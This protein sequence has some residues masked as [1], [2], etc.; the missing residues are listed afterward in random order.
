MR[1]AGSAL[2]VAVIF[3]A[4]LAAQA[5]YS[6]GDG[7]NTPAVQ[8]H[9][10]WNATGR[11][12]NGSAWGNWA[13]GGIAR[14]FSSADGPLAS[15]NLGSAVR[16]GGLIKEATAQHWTVIN[17]AGHPLNF[18]H[19]SSISVNLNT[20]ATQGGAIHGSQLVFTGTR[21]GTVRIGPTAGEPAANGI[22]GLT[23]ENITLKLSKNH[24]VAALGGAVVVNSGIL[25]HGAA[26]DIRRNNQYAAGSTL[27]V[28]GGFIHYWSTTQTLDSLTWN[29]G[30]FTIWAGANIN[31][32]GT[33]ALTLRNVTLRRTGGVPGDIFHV[34]LTRNG[35]QT[36][37][38][39]A[40]DNG[41][42]AISDGTALVL[43]G[44]EKTFYVENGNATTDMRVQV[45]S[46]SE[47][48]P[49]SLRKTGTGLL[50]LGGTAGHTGGTHVEAGTMLLAT[51][52]ARAPDGIITVADGASLGLRCHDGHF[53]AGDFAALHA[54]TLER[55]SMA[56]G[57]LAGFENNAANPGLLA[58]SLT[59]TRG[60]EKLGS[61][62]L[63]LTADNTYSGPTKIT[64]GV[65][66]IGDGGTTGSITGDVEFAPSID[67]FRTLRFNRNGT[68]VHDGRISG[69]GAVLKDGP[70]TVI[71]TGDCS[72]TGT[73]TVI[74][75]ELVISNNTFRAV[76]TRDSLAVEF[77]EFPANGDYM[78]LPGGIAG[79]SLSNVTIT[80]GGSTLAGGVF[81]DSPS[82]GITIKQPP[83]A[84][85]YSPAEIDF[86]AGLEIPPF[87]PAVTGFPSSYAVTPALPSGLMLDPQ[88]GVI[89]GTPLATSARTSHIITAT[90]NAGATSTEISIVIYPQGFVRTTLSYGNGTTTPAVQLN[91]DWNTAGRW[92]DG[93][94]WRDWTD[95]GIARFHTPA[96]GP[97]ATINLGSS[98]LLGGLVKAAEANHWTV[99]N[100]SG[101]AL[102]FTDRST[103]S[104]NLNTLA[105]QGGAIHG[106]DLS[107]TGTPGGFVRIG[108]VA[109]EAVA[110]NINGLT[111]DNIT[112]KLS[113]NHGV[114]AVGG[115]VT[116]NGGVLE[117]GAA[118]DTRRN[119]QYAADS[120][121]TLN[122]GTLSYWSTTQT[123]DSLTWNAGVFTI[124][125]NANLN[126][127]GTHALT[128][129]NVMLT[130]TGGSVGQTYQVNLTK[131]GAQTVRFDASNNG[132]ATLGE[133]TALVLGGG[134]K[135]IHIENG[136]AITDMQVLVNSITESAPSSI[137]KTGPGL[138][139]WNV[140]AA[141][142]HSGGMTV[143]NGTLLLVSPNSQPASGM[144]V[145]DGATLALRMH[146]GQFTQQ[147]FLNLHAGTH[148]GV[149]MAAA[150]IAGWESSAGT[151]G[152]IA[153]PL[154]GTRGL[155]K[156]GAGVLILTG[157]NTYSGGTVIH[158]G[159]LQ[160][161]NGGS[162]GS[163]TGNVFLQ[164]SVN[165]N[166][167]LSFNRSDTV[168]YN[169]DISG[170][171][172]LVKEGGGRLVLTGEC[173]H[174]GLTT[175]LAG[176]LDIS[177]ESFNAVLTPDSIT[178]DFREFPTS[179]EYRILAG[180]IGGNS[181]A[182]TTV[183]V[184]GTVL[185][186]AVFTNTSS[187][188]VSIVHP[189]HPMS[190]GA[191]FARINLDHPGLEAV[192]D[193]VLAGN[194]PAA[195]TALAGY[196]RTRA[197]VFH[198][199]DPQDPAAFVTDPAA[200]LAAAQELV[201]R[202]GD[203][204][205][206]LWDGNHFDWERASMPGKERME[207]LTILGQ[208]AAVETGDEA[209]QS[210]VHLIRSFI[211]Q[212]RA[213]AS[214]LGD[215]FWSTMD[216]GIRLRT[217]WPDAFCYLLNNPSSFTDHDIMF[218][219]KSVWEQT[220]YL[221]RNLNASTGPTAFVT[222]GLYA[223]GTVHP[224]FRDAE[225][226]RRVACES[227]HAD[228]ARGWLP[229]GVGIGKSPENGASFLNHLHVHRIA[230]LTGRLD[231]FN[232][233]DL[234]LHGLPARTEQMFDAYLH[235]MTPDR[236]TPALN[237]GGPVHVPGILA[238][239]LEYFPNRD[240]YRWIATN[241]AAGGAP[242]TTTTAMPYAGY[243]VM[244][245]GWA[246]DDNY[247]LFDAGGVGHNHAHQDKL[248]LVMWA[249]GRRILLDSPQATGPGVDPAF[250][251][252]FR[253]TFAH[254]TGLVDGRPQRRPWLSDPDPDG[255]PYQP[256]PDFRREIRSDG[257][258]W[259][260]GAYSGDYGLPG[261]RANDS[262]PNGDASLF[263][264][265]WGRPASH[266][267]E[268]M[269]LAPDVFVVQDWF[270]P[271][272]DMAH[273]C[274]VRWQVDSTAVLADGL[275]AVTNDP[276]V[277]NLAI[278]PLDTNGLSTSTSSGVLTADEIAG[279]KNDNG[280]P[281]PATTLHHRKSGSG[282]QR[283][284]T[285]LYPLR[286]GASPAGL[287]HESTLDGRI[288]IRTPDGRHFALDPSPT[289]TGS[290]AKLT[291]LQAWRQR[292]FGAAEAGAP[293]GDNDSYAGDTT[294][295]LIKYALGIEPTRSATPGELPRVGSVPGVNDKHLSLQFQRQRN[296]PDV[297]MR[298]QASDDLVDWSKAIWDSRND[299][300]S[301]GNGALEEIEV[302]DPVPMKQHA[303]GRNFLRLEVSRLRQDLPEFNVQITAPPTGDSAAVFE[304][305][306]RRI[307]EMAETNDISRAVVSVA[308]GNYRF[309][310]PLII[311]PAKLGR[312]AGQ[313]VIEATGDGA[314]FSGSTPIGNWRLADHPAL[315]AAAQGKVWMA[316]LPPGLDPKVLY[317]A[318]GMLPRSRSTGFAPAYSES[319][320]TNFTGPTGILPADASLAGVE[321]SVR[322]YHLWIHNILP[323]A[324][325][326][327]ATGAGTTALPATYRISLV[328]DWLGGIVPASAW[329]ENHPALISQAGHWA[330]DPATGKLYVWPRAGTGAPAGIQAPQLIELLRLQGDLDAEIPL[331]GVTLRGLTFSRADRESIGPDD[332]GL[333]HDWDFMDKTNAML[334]LRW[335]E[336]ITVE[337]CR[338]V[339]SGAAGMRA[340]LHAQNVRV[341]GNTFRGLGGGGVLFCGYGPGTKDLNKNNEIHG[342]LIEDCGRIIWHSPGIHLW[343]SGENRVTR[344][345]VRD[346]PYTGII[347]SGAGAHNFR[348]A[349]N[350][351][352]ELERTIR[353]G[354]VP[355]DVNYTTTSIQ[356]YIHTRNNLIAGN[357]ITGVMRTLGDGNAIYIRFSSQT[358][359]VIRGNHVHHI[360]GPR[361]AGA[362]RCD[363]EQYGVT[364]EGNYIHRVNFTGVSINGRNTI[365]N[366]FF[367]DILN[368]DNSTAGQSPIVRACIMAWNQPS[369]R[370]SEIRRNVFLQTTAGTPAFYYLTYATYLNPPPAPPV[371]ED[372]AMEKNVYWVAG[373]PAHAVDFVADLHRRGIDQGSLAADTAVSTN[374]AGLPVFNPDL[375]DQL[376]ITPF[377]WENVG[378]PWTP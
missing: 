146:G 315:P 224:E 362:I 98:I 205:A 268:V 269:Q 199:V 58:T 104:V 266:Q 87:S 50:A 90:N 21:N 11:W 287:T 369:S 137:R 349:E 176:Q 108:P 31:L 37:R 64:Q 78:I 136:S 262:N 328:P 298:V 14:F 76:L 368:R 327:P 147:Q 342:N 49:S 340:D 209:A 210:L 44:G 201:D 312:F 219:L 281:L 320:D 295:N 326:N 81:A 346:M 152:L 190:D 259:A 53:T 220:D 211:S 192:R 343:Q 54:G 74:A 333:Q 332:A 163:I 133:G 232:T 361:N 153:A 99:L 5:V 103:I 121:L 226:W 204:D 316:D 203:W 367:V 265:G 314:V 91:G 1:H 27:T 322:P 68:L 119:N 3:S 150:A 95:G 79:N 178:V 244:R 329:I 296:A 291:G 169:G 306:L 29:D 254:S 25:E 274:E 334:R 145:S 46:I 216:T 277:P 138:V 80:T 7:T 358:G 309:D 116:V 352:R 227:I 15:I 263:G 34:N 4:P 47:S 114:P 6:Y 371:L 373:N 245:S 258:S 94:A 213:P 324:S 24:G 57:A 110:N 86:V 82:L 323:L 135:T 93:T 126:L 272:D 239:G 125:A 225:S 43:G 184:G 335:V 347:I 122:G 132:T 359:N 304:E 180:G 120:T 30:V 375:L 241:G 170:D 70:G 41:T 168:I 345:L 175:V 123:L 167:Q 85:T 366:N 318:E 275:D 186:G 355:Q 28:N 305:A 171:G 303:E 189:A 101:H 286:A 237:D 166:P 97:F 365:R 214:G 202:T 196:Y 161:G 179:S 165:G 148:S 242:A 69:P 292:W 36:V 370:G 154:G 160:I 158:Q 273:D 278:R 374:P 155:A 141:N 378:L 297:L 222:A 51:A 128:L 351:A 35:A 339:E 84:L 22:N 188:Q 151:P 348:N 299:P 113:K 130:R 143:E 264:S 252:F 247:L 206:T 321:L 26:F 330:A 229:D 45:E 9:G 276:G 285:L 40:G 112:L 191:F 61:G 92:H 341:S 235:L 311:D 256:V 117:H 363:D 270:V 139:A 372:F 228:L 56:A 162:S 250:E 16:L 364:I 253:D 218:F 283:F 182:H 134:A 131:N 376:G 66:Q 124:W 59:G 319:T 96:E 183:T 271:G 159:K 8:L 38:F 33:D 118:F 174:T 325:Y 307:R 185:P 107:F 284:L 308:P 127:A 233:P 236:S 217:G 144:A 42:A 223:S 198:T 48:L 251:N 140:D 300:P 357:E 88:T 257:S 10:D 221:A 260:A 331:T 240:D 115:A 129:R 149:T 63:V 157:E 279:W 23:L 336:D 282:P 100:Q 310:R 177:N 77:H 200:S 208:A 18:D 39:D 248:Q 32:G 317:D 181:L 111:L 142:S 354:E 55:V 344:N 302:V 187:L 230:S 164:P 290:L 67:G 193:A 267:R 19:G 13:D 73:T 156:L 197:G 246:H 173:D 20:L 280:T 360:T 313:L 52:S 75:G 255:M 294:P 105:T 172:T 194:L 289:Y 71:L 17:Q 377:D 231:E 2:A 62:T 249:Y 106:N 288:S 301:P 238:R 65:L 261:S 353:W 212:Y 83:S 12:H 234:A 337:N 109:G 350:P 207:F 195:R 89:S 215:G 60:L 338:F 293:T 72:H 102:N 356:P 243:M